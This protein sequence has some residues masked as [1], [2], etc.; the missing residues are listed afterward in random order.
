MHTFIKGD[1][2][3]HELLNDN[4]DELSNTINSNNDDQT[5]ALK[6]VTEDLPNYAKT[7]DVTA[8]IA[9]ATT[10]LYQ[11]TNVGLGYGVTATLTRIGNLVN[12][13]I[14]SN[15]T[16]SRPDGRASLTETIPSGYRP[17]NT[18]IAASNAYQADN[19]N[20]D[21]F[22]SMFFY[23]SGAIESLSKN[24]TSGSITVALSA[25]WLTSDAVPV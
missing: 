9:A 23:A 24:M 19:L 4:F 25:T 16:S 14:N 21:R 22:M 17:T 15:Q 6:A 12:I 20:A 13:S 8:D 1:S 7:A 2:D 10:K 11:K 3:Y 5:N 18:Q